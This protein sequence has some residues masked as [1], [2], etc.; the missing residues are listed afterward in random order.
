[1]KN[2]FGVVNYLGSRFDCFLKGWK[3]KKLEAVSAND[4]VCRICVR[5]L[6]GSYN[7][8]A[9][10]FCNTAYFIPMKHSDFKWCWKRFLKCLGLRT[11][12]ETLCGCTWELNE[13]L[14]ADT[15]VSTTT[16]AYMTLPL[17][18][19]SDAAMYGEPADFYGGKNS[20]LPYSLY[21][22]VPTF[23]LRI[24]ENRAPFK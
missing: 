20:G 19:F 5:P 4:N 14:K 1:M 17:N 9:F 8:F 23:K 6:H 21:C 18:P 3:W 2:A 15:H 11:P 12:T 16:L 13:I 22:V 7:S 10:C 24:L